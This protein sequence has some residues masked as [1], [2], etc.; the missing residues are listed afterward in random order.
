MIKQYVWN[1]LSAVDRVANALTGGSPD[2]TISSRAGKA[3]AAGKTWAC[4]LCKFLDLFDKNH[5]KKSINNEDGDLA[6]IPE[7]DVV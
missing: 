2:E 3:Q 5:C 7:K 1:F 6:I 4:V